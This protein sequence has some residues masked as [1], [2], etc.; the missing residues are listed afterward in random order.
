MSGIATLLSV[1]ARFI[2]NKVVSVYVGPAGLTLIGQ[3]QN[4][5]AFVLSIANGSINTGVTKYLAEKNSAQDVHDRNIMM[6]ALWVNVV[7]AL[8]SGVVVFLGAEYWAKALLADV[9]YAPVFKLFSVTLLFFALNTLFMAVLN[10]KKNIKTYISINI[11]GSLIGLCMSV[12]LV[13]LF[14]LTGGL[15]AIVTNQSII[16]LVTCVFVMRTQ[17]PNLLFQAQRFLPSREHLKK[18]G[19]F[20][21][22]TFTAAAVTPF[23]NMLIRTNLIDHFGEHETGYWQGVSYISIMYLMMITTSLKTYLLP[24]F[25]EIDAPEGLRGEFRYAAMIIVPLVIVSAAVIYFMRDYI[26]VIA[27]SSEFFE[28]RDLFLWQLVGDVLKIIGWLFGIML[29]AKAMIV[30]SMIANVSFGFVLYVLS[31]VMVDQYGLVGATYAYAINYA[32]FLPFVVFLAWPAFV[33]SLKSNASK[34]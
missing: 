13:Y 5:V 27:F 11:L 8:L 23:V 29:A 20:A 33:G 15:Y 22:M 1:I 31:I 17:I 4:F 12:T 3:L 26:I 28:M 18:L 30:R 24:K 16:F 2:I 7:C 6:S 32:L 34:D 14:G 9:K 19:M 25:S 10:G 21:L